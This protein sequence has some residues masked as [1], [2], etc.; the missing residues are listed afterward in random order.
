MTDR[1]DPADPIVGFARHPAAI[2]GRTLLRP[3][4]PAPSS[5]LE[6]GPQAGDEAPRDAAIWDPA[7][8]YAPPGP[9]T[10]RQPM[11]DVVMPLASPPSLPASRQIAR[12][13][14]RLMPVLGEP[15]LP[16]PAQPLPAA[17]EPPAP[18][19]PAVLPP[20]PEPEAETSL[21]LPEHEPLLPEALPPEPLPPDALE[22]PEPVPEPNPAVETAAPPTP[23]LSPVYDEAPTPPHE[24]ELVQV[25]EPQPSPEFVA[26][27]ALLP[28]PRRDRFG[29]LP[30]R[31][32]RR[33]QPSELFDTETDLPPGFDPQRVF[34]AP[35]APS[36]P[37]SEEASPPPDSQL[38]PDPNP[39]YAD[40]PVEDERPW[41]TEPDVVA[42][43][44]R[45][46]RPLLIPGLI[47]L[48]VLVGLVVVT[49]AVVSS[50]LSVGTVTAVFNAPMMVVRAAVTGRVMVISA[51]AGE[52]VDPKSPLFTIHTTDANSPDRSVLADVHGVIR[53]V[54]TVPGADLTAG[55]PLVRIHDCDRAFLTVPQTAK[56]TPGETVRVKLPNYAAVTG[57]IRTSVGIMEPPNSVVVG[58]PPNAI[59]GACPVGVKADV[60]PMPKG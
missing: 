29:F 16:R 22:E 41:G 59:P 49:V 12:S 19:L 18:E 47:A 60:T 43:R 28:R 45:R 1:F 48:A 2:G 3:A 26:S 6:P 37:L 56:L 44:G 33:S 8:R 53:S 39:V 42:N 15:D 36:H 5:P 52:I 30:G 50:L 51:N 35:D 4:Y 25:P 21:V 17:P 40:L 23:P 54:E 10:V 9:S 27:E 11:L 57:T 20:L 32:R 55:T 38:W 58:L 24:P 46:F 34:E 7:A 13:Q 31:F 14:I